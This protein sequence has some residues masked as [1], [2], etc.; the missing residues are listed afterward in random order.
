MYTLLAISFFSSFL[1]NITNYINETS[2]VRNVSEYNKCV[3]ASWYGPGFHGRKTADGSIF[4][5][6]ELTAAHKS[7]SFGTQ[8]KIINPNNNET[9]TVTI[10]DRGP[11]VKNRSLDLSRA[12][13]QSLG[14]IEQG[15]I[16]VCYKKL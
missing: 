13:M 5:Q 7:Y 2:I 4:N 10:N 14:G 12:A 8:L 6:N 9:V 3:N 1:T 16:K 15:V 11:F